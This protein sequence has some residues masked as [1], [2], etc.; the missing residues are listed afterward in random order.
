MD[1]M[2]I[3]VNNK[4]VVTQYLTFA[5]K[6]EDYGLEIAVVTEIIR[7]QTIT[8]VP[9]LP[10]YIK[11]IINLRGR[12]IPVMDVRV[13]FSIEPQEYDDRTCIIVVDVQGTNIGMIVDTV[14]GVV[15][16]ADEDVT[17]PSS[18]RSGYENRYISGIGK[19]PSGVKLLLNLDKVVSDY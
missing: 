15:D 2:E 1:E 13:R 9:E 16:I 3:Q 8:Q 11:G 17:D 5:I 6:E 19:T 10:D 12:I 7:V 18:H 4:N 14:R